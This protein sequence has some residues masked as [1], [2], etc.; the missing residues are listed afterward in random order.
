MTVS[1]VLSTHNGEPFLGEQ[2]RSLADQ[3]VLPDEL[4]ARDDGSTD[5][6]LAILESFQRQ[7]PFP[8]RVFSG[9]RIG[10]KKSFWDAARS[11]TGDIVAFC[12]QDDVWRP[13]KV[14]TIK[15]AFTPETTMV[16]HGLQAFDSASGSVVGRIGGARARFVP[17]P[18]GMG[19]HFVVHG[20]A[21]AFRRSVLEPHLRLPLPEYD[22]TAIFCH[23]GY[24]CLLA[25]ASGG[26]RLLPD[27]LVRY[28][29]HA[30]NVTDSIP[31]P[32]PLAAMTS[33]FSS[34]VQAA[35]A[36]AESARYYES[37]AGFFQSHSLYASDPRVATIAGH[38]SRMAE[39]CEK[40]AEVFRGSSRAGS[41][42]LVARNLREGVYG[43]HSNAGLGWRAF[44]GDLLRVVKL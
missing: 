15:A 24:A 30:R 1:V 4:V 23:D 26:V 20:C 7:A 5:G 18:M 42:W 17:Q 3:A 44:A 6:T 14:A 12:D 33:R 43:P 31:E 19:Y 22:Q 34:R 16:G 25:N 9:E 39:H 38:L 37:L 2:L 40:R 32:V 13:E 41:L 29:R 28:R 27:L 36:Y 21:A 10:Y 11:A 35:K 8:V